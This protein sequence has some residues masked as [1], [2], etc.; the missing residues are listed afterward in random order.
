MRKLQSRQL[1]RRLKKKGGAYTPMN[2]EINNP[3]MIHRRSMQDDDMPM[4]MKGDDMPMRMQS[5]DMPMRMQGN[6]MPMPMQGNNNCP[7]CVC[8]TTTVNE[9]GEK[10]PASIKDRVSDFDNALKNKPVEIF[11]GFKTDSFNL[12][13][14]KKDQISNNIIGFLSKGKEQST[15]PTVGGRRRSM[16]RKS[17]TARKTTTKRKIYIK[18]RKT[19]T[20]RS[21][22]KRHTRR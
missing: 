22:K 21:K 6:D 17:K 3:Q 2:Y 16:R 13:N 7:P 19:T 14:S 15:V 9:N 4:R 1:K 5:D 8:P 10:P 12:F 11:N 20:R 18:K